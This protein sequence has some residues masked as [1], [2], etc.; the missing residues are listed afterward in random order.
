MLEIGE[1]LR[2]ARERRLLSYADVEAATHIPARYVGAL[3]DEAFHRLPE[4]LY[5]RSFL[6]EYADFLGLDGNAYVAELELRDGPTLSNAPVVPATVRRRSW[7]L[8]SLWNA[9]LVAGVLVAVGIAAWTLARDH[10]RKPP[11]AAPLP[12]TPRM[13]R[14]TTAPPA[15]TAPAP[16]KPAPTLVLT[17]ARG[18]CWLS[19]QIRSSGKTVYEQTL[20]QGG[21]LRFGLKQPLVIRFGAPSN[22]T[23]AI[24]G[25]DVTG[26]LPTDAVASAQGLRAAG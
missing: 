2:E 4:G 26:T 22:V 25:H 6:R 1:S 5:R 18:S 10:G 17:A 19:V 3:E 23:A 11:R 9:A 16:P 24:G 15:T 7:Q 8:P 13:P 14:T 20:A 12:T 21:S